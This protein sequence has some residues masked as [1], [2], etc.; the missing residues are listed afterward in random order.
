MP[1]ISRLGG[2]TDGS[3]SV[4]VEEQVATQNPEV[5]PDD[6]RTY[7]VEKQ[8]VR[9]QGDEQ[10]VFSDG[11]EDADSEE[12]DDKEEEPKKAPAPVAPAKKTATSIKHVEGKR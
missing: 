2:V 1:K 7:E 4:P 6:I 5:D 3:S 11:G 12:E 10:I 8:D 9:T